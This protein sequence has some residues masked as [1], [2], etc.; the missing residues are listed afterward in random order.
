MDGSFQAGAESGY[1]AAHSVREMPERFQDRLTLSNL[2]LI[3]RYVEAEIIIRV[4]F[5]TDQKFVAYFQGAL[6]I[7]RADEQIH[8]GMLGADRKPRTEFLS[9]AFWRF[10]GGQGNSAN[11]GTEV[12]A[13]KRSASGKND[14]VFVD[15][16]Q[17]VQ[18][19]ELVP[20]PSFVRLYRLECVESIISQPSLLFYS[21]QRGFVFTGFV[22]DRNW[23][24]ASE[25]SAPRATSISCPL[26]W[27]RAL[28]RFWMASPMI[29]GMLV[30]TG[31]T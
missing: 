22:P 14:A 8:H 16:V 23:V 1:G 17:A 5:Q 21:S 12:D 19:P 15:V 10:V 29:P 31:S 11:S 13:A 28:R 4:Q 20:V 2:R 30:G 18:H 3:Q 9:D 7:C 26:K 24:S 6:D 27:S 25:R